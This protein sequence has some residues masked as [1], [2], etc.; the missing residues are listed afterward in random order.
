MYKSTMCYFKSKV[1]RKALVI[2]R[3]FSIGFIVKP[4]GMQSWQHFAVRHTACFINEF[5]NNQ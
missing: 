5:T 2:N 3:T 4:D 1:F